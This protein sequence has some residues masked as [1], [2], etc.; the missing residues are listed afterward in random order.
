MPIYFNARAFAVSNR[1]LWASGKE[2]IFGLLKGKSIE[3][4]GAALRMGTQPPRMIMERYTEPAS[5]WSSDEPRVW[6]MAC[7]VG[8]HGPDWELTVEYFGIEEHVP[9]SD[10]SIGD[11]LHGKK[12][13]HEVYLTS[14]KGEVFVIEPAPGNDLP[15]TPYINQLVNGPQSG[16]V[17]VKSKVNSCIKSNSISNGMLDG[18]VNSQCSCM[19]DRTTTAIAVFSAIGSPIAAAW[20]MVLFDIISALKPDFRIGISGVS[21]GI[22][23]NSLSMP[24]NIRQFVRLECKSHVTVRP[25]SAPALQVESGA[26]QS[27]PVIEAPKA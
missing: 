4:L 16:A 12:L 13:Y 24:K 22:S 3:A 9:L 21:N 18:N 19:A 27:M 5:I 2:R 8:R 25:T 6:L 26:G 14:W 1:H 23:P 7:R 17:P 11:M 10:V 15:R 20:W